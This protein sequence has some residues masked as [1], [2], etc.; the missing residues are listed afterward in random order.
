VIQQTLH[1]TSTLGPRLQL[2]T[3]QPAP[4]EGT[5]YT[6][7][8]EQNETKS[9]TRGASAPQL[10]NVNIHHTTLDLCSPIP[11]KG[12]RVVHVCVIMLVLVACGF[13]T[14]GVAL[15]THTSC[16]TLWQTALMMVTADDA[17]MGLFTKLRKPQDVV[18]EREP[19]PEATVSL[20]KMVTFMT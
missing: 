13:C 18:E 14:P 12:E 15:L 1:T 10:E 19:Q 4:Q 5:T 20:R 8:K 17:R 2:H 9:P 16:G 11:K 3:D 6:C 7:E